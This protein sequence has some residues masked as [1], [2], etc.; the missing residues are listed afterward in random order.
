VCRVFPNPAHKTLYV[1]GPSRE[2]KPWLAT[3]YDITGKPMLCRQTS[4]D[5]FSL[6]IHSLSPGM[7]VFRLQNGYAVPLVTEKIFVQ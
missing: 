4:E 6:D 3:L 2:R 1:E 5:H 7:Y